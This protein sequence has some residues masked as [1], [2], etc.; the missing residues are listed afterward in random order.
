MQGDFCANERWIWNEYDGWAK[1]LPRA[2]NHSKRWW[3]IHPSEEIQKGPTKEVR[4][5]WS[6]TYM[7]T[8]MHPSVVIDKDEKGNDTL[9]KEHKGVIDSLLY[10][11][12]SRPN[13]VFDV[14]LCARFQSC[15]KVSHVTA[16]KWILRYLVGTINHGLWFK[17]G[18]EF[19]LVSYCNADF[20]GDKVEWKSTN[21]TCQFLEKS[22][23]SWSSKKQS[24]IALKS[25]GSSNKFW[26]V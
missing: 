17:K 11:T 7:A 1:V 15:P 18:F 24:T 22:L 10:L 4:N 2:S 3:N 6:Q 19:D 8:L 14:C 23:V 25:F 26:I 16:V 5:G 13:I 21:G 9:E 12:A 20:V